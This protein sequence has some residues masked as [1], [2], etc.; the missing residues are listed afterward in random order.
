[1]VSLSNML[2]V[3]VAVA[4]GILSIKSSSFICR[5]SIKLSAENVDKSRVNFALEQFYRC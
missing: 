3:L 4:V 5:S 1:M 2:L